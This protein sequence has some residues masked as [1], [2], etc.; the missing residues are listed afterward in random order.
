CVKTALSARESPIVFLFPGQ[1]SQYVNMGRGLYDTMPVFRENV[2]TC[3]DIIRKSAGYD[4]RSMVYPASGLEQESA[5][6]LRQT[7]VTQPALFTIEYALAKQ[8][9]AW[10]IRPQ[11]MIGHSIGEYVAACLAGVFDLDDALELVSKRGF[12]I[13]ETKCG[14]MLAVNLG[15]DELGWVLNADLSLA[16][17]NGPRL[18]V[19][20][21]TAEA[22]EALESR[23]AVEGVWTRRLVTSHA[24]HSDMM[25]GVAGRFREAV[26]GIQLRRP[27]IDYISNVTGTWANADQVT[28]PAYW[29]EHMRGTVRFG[30]GVQEL[31]RDPDRVFLEVGPGRTLSTLVKKIA[32]GGLKAEPVFCLRGPDESES[33]SDERS[34]LDALGRLWLN[35]AVVNWKA[36]HANKARRRV[37]LPT[38]PFER[39]SYWIGRNSPIVAKTGNGENDRGPESLHPRPILNTPYEPAQTPLETVLCRIWADALGSGQVGINDNYFELGGDS[40]IGVQIA[41]AAAREGISITPRD[42]FEHPTVGALSSAIGDLKNNKNNQEPVNKESPPPSEARQPVQGSRPIDQQGLKRII[43]K[44]GKSKG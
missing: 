30:A 4:L 39:L 6:A 13:Q 9:Q 40:I 17:A 43:K 3:C 23:L 7:R 29:V 41:T 19:V 33:E 44:I 27:E 42:L 25:E 21:G 37:A 24:F 31:L 16:A 11:A 22:V 26:S 32:G 10:G 18:S 8:W 38:Y 1:G 20:S 35:G 28:K 14:A 36:L 12:L 2:D 34:M 5:E 15:E